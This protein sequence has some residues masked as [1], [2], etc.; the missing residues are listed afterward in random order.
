[1]FMQQ[2]IEKCYRHI[3]NKSKAV[4]LNSIREVEDAEEEEYL[5]KNMLSEDKDWPQE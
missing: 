5:M 2:N 3:R 4:F 1:M